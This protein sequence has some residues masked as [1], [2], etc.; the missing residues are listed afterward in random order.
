MK[1]EFAKYTLL[2]QYTDV[3][4]QD[5]YSVEDLKSLSE[6]RKEEDAK[7]NSK[8]QKERFNDVQLPLYVVIEP[9]GD[10]FKEVARYEYSVITDKDHF[11]KFLRDHAGTK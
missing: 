9:V 3:V 11:L 5:Y 4:P 2:K 7:A 6:D 8:F 1:A 10:D